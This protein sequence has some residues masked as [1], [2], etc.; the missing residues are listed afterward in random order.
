MNKDPPKDKA[1]EL[2]ERE[3]ETC[4]GVNHWIKRTLYIANGL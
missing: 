1:R 3:R 4:Q 2:R